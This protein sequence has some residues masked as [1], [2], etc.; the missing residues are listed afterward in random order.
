MQCDRFRAVAMKWIEAD[1][2]PDLRS[3]CASRTME[4]AQLSARGRIT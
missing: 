3:L 4:I 1:A 2:L